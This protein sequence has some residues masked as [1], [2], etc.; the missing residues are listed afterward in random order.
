[1]QQ[2]QEALNDT[3]LIADME[4]VFQAQRAVDLGNI[5]NELEGADL[6]RARDIILREY[7]AAVMLP[8]QTSWFILT[9][10][11]K[12]IPLP[13]ELCDNANGGGQTSCTCE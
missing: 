1:M 11:Q 6:T 8:T 13:T 5:T 3:L 12:A 10:A 7:M 4:A 9:M 2:V